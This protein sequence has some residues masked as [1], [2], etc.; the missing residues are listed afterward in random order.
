MKLVKKHKKALKKACS[1]YNVDELYVF[2]SI[3]TDNFTVESDIDFLVSILSDGPLE[4]AENYFHLK[5][6]LERIF[7]R[8]IDLLEY[9]AIKNKVF[10]NLIDQNKV[11]VY[12]REH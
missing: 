1:A 6:E 12:A 11:L 3:L 4:Y 7:K 8:E 5:F 9:K 10:L 2:G